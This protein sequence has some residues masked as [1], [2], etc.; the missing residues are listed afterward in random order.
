MKTI[1]QLARLSWR[2]LW[3]RPLATALNL[4]LLTKA[5]G[6]RLLVVATS[7]PGLPAAFEADLPGA[8]VPAVLRLEGLAPDAARSLVARALRVARA[9]RALEDPLVA[10]T[11]GNPYFLLETIAD[12]EAAGRLVRRGDAVVLAG[13]RDVPSLPASVRDLLRARLATLA[14]DDRALLEAAACAGDEPDPVVVGHE[15]PARVVHDEAH[16]RGQELEHLDTARAG[17]LALRMEEANDTAER[18]GLLPCDGTDRRRPAGLERG[19]AR[20]GVQRKEGRFLADRRAKIGSARVERLKDGPRHAG[21]ETGES[22]GELRRQRRG[23][24]KRQAGRAGI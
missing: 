18:R 2:Y 20:R 22:S 8:G 4:L 16:E 12:L 14:P 1:A 7:R 23:G 17:A 6:R 11:G 15:P 10:A 9:P 3:S 21:L 5:E 13:P 19:G 24:E